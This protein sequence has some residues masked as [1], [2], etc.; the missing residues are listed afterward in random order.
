[1]M[2]LSGLPPSPQ[3]KQWQMFLAGDTINEGV[4][5]SW[6]GQS[7]FRLAPER[8]RVMKSLTTSTMLAASIILS[9]VALSII[10]V[11]YI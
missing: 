6:N 9:L 4:R 3:A 2:K 8:F 11:V 1:M 5:S 7:P 10:F